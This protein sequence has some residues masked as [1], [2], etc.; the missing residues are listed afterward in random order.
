MIKTTVLSISSL[1]VLAASAAPPV[2]LSAPDGR[3]YPNVSFAGVPGGIPEIPV[4]VKVE[5]FG[6]KPGEDVSGAIEAAA[7]AAAGKGGGAVLLGPGEFYIDRPI[8][9]AAP[10]VVLRGSGMKKTRIVFRWEPA[11]DSVDFIGIKDGDV[12][13]KQKSLFVAAWND[14][15]DNKV[16]KCL[17]RVSLEINGKLAAEQT[18]GEGPWFCISPDNRKSALMLQPGE[19]TLRA[20]AEYIDGRSAVKEIKVNVSEDAGLIGASAG[21]AAITFA[22]PSALNET[23]WG[24]ITEGTPMMRGQDSVEFKT[25]PS[26]QQGDLVMLAILNGGYGESPIM[27]IEENTGNSL[28]LKQA[29]RFDFPLRNIRRI[30]V[31]R[32]CGLEDMTIEQTSGHWTNLVAFARDFGCWMQR[33]RLVNAGRF[34]ITG[35]TKNFEMR[36][37]EI[38]GAQY[39][40]GVGGGSGYVA[41]SSAQD[42]LMENIKTEKLRHAPD[43]QHGAQGCV[44][45]A[46]VFEDSDAQ[47][48]R[49]RTYDNLLEN[50]TVNSRGSNK[51][52][53]SYGPAVTVTTDPKTADVGSGNVI[54]KNTFT[55]MNVYK[56]GKAF[57]LDCGP[58]QGWLVAYNTF[59]SDIGCAIAS[60]GAGH[61]ILF[62]NN[63][64]SVANA[65]PPAVTGDVSAL[66]L[67]GNSFA[68][69]AESEILPAGGNPAEFTGNTVTP[70][71]ETP[72]PKIPSIYLWQKSLPASASG[73]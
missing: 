47:F 31:L 8:L 28:L 20:T 72:E 69:Y 15:R 50:C 4:V 33:V 49:G 41:F 29:V 56:G 53:G 9:I 46:S 60:N 2:E 25:P 68:G 16:V 38:S 23:G 14:S 57:A 44:I 7:T 5:D 12:I 35:M 51:S 45:R 42:C 26:W 43:F 21:D 34:P 11:K 73:R 67:V 55:S 58:A 62:L 52:F 59:E 19:N 6:G 17:K 66:R 24:S 3:N 30:P 48:H 61:D 13:P 36:D 32:G 1:L 64:F 40:F 27:E 65:E 54:Y 10:G 70:P 39:H 71:A 22:E 18:G 37:S 63:S